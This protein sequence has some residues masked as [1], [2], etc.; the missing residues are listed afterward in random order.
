MGR[1][2]GQTQFK[3][4]IDYIK[5]ELVVI[6][7]M[8]SP[9]IKKV[10]CYLFGSIL[11]NPVLANDIDILIIYENENQIDIIKKAF[12]DLL[13]NFPV[14]MSYFTHEEVK[15]LNFIRQQNAKKIFGT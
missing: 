4:E 14:H 7:N 2:D 1:I 13:I 9:K 10:D 3:M 5:Q 11:R 12:R 8:L 15:E 6:G